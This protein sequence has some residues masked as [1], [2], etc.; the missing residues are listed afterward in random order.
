[1][2]HHY[3]DTEDATAASAEQAELEEDFL[4]SAEVVE[5]SQLAEHNA[6]LEYIASVLSMISSIESAVP[7][8]PNLFVC[9]FAY[10]IILL[11]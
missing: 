2:T 11:D 9:I 4:A 10:V 3:C 1:M 8:V 7:K 5:D 6:K